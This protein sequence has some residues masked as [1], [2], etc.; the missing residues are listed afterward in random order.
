MI[1]EFLRSKYEQYL[2]GLDIYE[3]RTSLIL[4]RIIIKPEARGSGVGSKIMEDLINYA[5]KNK[6][7]IALTPSSDFGGNKNRLVQFYKKFGFKHNKGQYKSFEFRDAMIRYPKL[8]ETM[9]PLI[10]TLL[11]EGLMSQE[12]SVVRQVSDFVNFAKDFLGVDDNVK[13][14]LAFEKTPDI[15]TTAYYNPYDKLIKVYVK[16]RAI[17]DVCRSI[18]HELVHHKQNI[19]GRLNDIA[20]DGSDGSPIE[21]E[22]NALAGV[23][24][25]KY[26]KQNAHLYD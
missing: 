13:I 26:G 2:D 5:D 9:K 3:N 22:A 12:D 23:I 20:N 14:A 10:K 19:D 4:S 1:E 7:I 16:D 15:T 18:A 11:R 21:N 24:I 17:M 8:N 25:R 6:Q